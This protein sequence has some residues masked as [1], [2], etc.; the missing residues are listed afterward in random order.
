MHKALACNLFPKSFRWTCQK[1][2]GDLNYDLSLASIYRD[3]LGGPNILKL[4]ALLFSLAGISRS[5]TMSAV[6]IISVTGLSVAEALQAIRSSRTIANPNFGFQKQ[7]HD[8]EV[9]GGA[10]KV[11]QT[12]Y[13]ESCGKYCHRYRIPCRIASRGKKCTTKYERWPIFSLIFLVCKE[14]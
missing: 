2:L 10:Q 12:P 8:F 11:S 4:F 7:L 5:V 6:Y 9:N 1:R 3:F 13:P 14:V